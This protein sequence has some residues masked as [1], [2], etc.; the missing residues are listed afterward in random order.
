MVAIIVIHTVQY[1]Y[2]EPIGQ[3]LDTILI[4]NQ[5]A[6]FAVPFFFCHIRIFLVCKNIIRPLDFHFIDKFRQASQCNFHPLVTDISG[7]FCCSILCERRSNCIVE[8]P[9]LRHQYGGK[10]AY[11][12]LT[13]RG[14]TS[15]IVFDSVAH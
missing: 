11:N 9:H 1:G 14:Q 5:T 12:L 13:R 15:F 7:D 2:G 3:K 4:A 8:R 6:R 10:F